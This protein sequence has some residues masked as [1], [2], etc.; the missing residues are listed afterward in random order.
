M[1]SIKK[2][3][4]LQNVTQQHGFS[5]AQLWQCIRQQISSHVCHLAPCRAFQPWGTCQ[6][7]LVDRALKW[8][9][10]SSEQMIGRWT[11]DRAI[12]RAIELGFIALLWHCWH[13]IRPQTLQQIK[14]NHDGTPN[15][16]L[17]N[18]GNLNHWGRC[19]REL[20]GADRRRIFCVFHKKPFRNLYSHAKNIVVRFWAS[21]ISKS[22]SPN[23][24]SNDIVKPTRTE[25]PRA[26]WWP[27]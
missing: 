6:G 9:A 25:S 3:N 16:S 2:N 15:R 17:S 27:S 23:R 18:P 21:Q 5:R 12:G 20:Y 19:F 24:I 10:R 7:R 22:G 26:V 4:L 13:P 1:R 11:H 14:N 8:R